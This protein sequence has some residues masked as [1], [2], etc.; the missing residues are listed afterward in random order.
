MQRA[1]R[2]SQLP[3]LTADVINVSDWILFCLWGDNCWTKFAAQL[4]PRL[5]QRSPHITVTATAYGG[6]VAVSR[7]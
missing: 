1:S 7:V 6:R 4:A 5:G 2:R 3:H